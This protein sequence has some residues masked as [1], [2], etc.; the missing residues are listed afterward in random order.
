MRY[1][2]TLSHKYVEIDKKYL[3]LQEILQKRP[4][5][6]ILPLVPKKVKHRN[7]VR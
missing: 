7:S 5:F 1:T 3:F 6:L 2:F 4:W